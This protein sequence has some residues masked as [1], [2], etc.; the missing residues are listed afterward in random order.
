MPKIGKLGLLA[1][2]KEYILDL[3][4]NLFTL[5]YVVSGVVKVAQDDTQSH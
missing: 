3:A 5:L 1:F 4:K 2:R